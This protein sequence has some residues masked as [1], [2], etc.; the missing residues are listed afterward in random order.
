LARQLIE[1]GKR[2]FVCKLV[3]LHLLPLPNVEIEDRIALEMASKALFD[4]AEALHHAT[5]RLCRQMVSFDE[6]QFARRAA[7]KGWKLPVQ[8]LA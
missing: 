3:L 2:L 1:S 6:Q 5:C 7:L 8:S 4:F